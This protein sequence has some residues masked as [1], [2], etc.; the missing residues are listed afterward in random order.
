MVGALSR[1]LSAIHRDINVQEKEYVLVYEKKYNR[2][3]TQRQYTNS[4]FVGRRLGDKQVC[5]QFCEKFRKV[6]LLD[7]KD[8]GSQW[9]GAS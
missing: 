4:L 9:L 5:S 8:G 7:P 3:I 2:F 6:G 1:Q